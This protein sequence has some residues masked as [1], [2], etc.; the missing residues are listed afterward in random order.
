MGSGGLETDPVLP[1]TGT[2]RVATR[3]HARMIP[4]SSLV[5][6]RMRQGV[7]HGYPLVLREKNRNK[8]ELERYGSDKPRWI[9][10][11]GSETGSE[12]HYRC[13]IVASSILP[14]RR[15]TSGNYEFTNVPETKPASSHDRARARA[16]ESRIKK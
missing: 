6:I 10:K 11:S 8:S 15:D 1:Y 13:H 9:F 16:K 2:R 14:Q 7:H 5:Q 3:A 12:F 4:Q